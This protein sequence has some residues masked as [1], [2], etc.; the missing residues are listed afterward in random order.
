MLPSVREVAELAGVSVGTVSNYLNRPDRVAQATRDKVAR[1]I[2]TL[3]FVPNGVARQLRAGR[4]MSIGLVVLDVGNP[5]FTDVARGA[6]MQAAKAGFN[7]LLAN[8]GQ[9]P[10]RE[11]EYLDLFE[12]QRAAGL[13][14][15][16]FGDPSARLREIRER[17]MPV[18]LVDRGSPDGAY[19]SVS[20]DDF[21]GGRMAAQHLL[22]IGRRK[23]AFVGGPLTIRQVADRFRGAVDA[24]RSTDGARVDL[25]EGTALSVDEGDRLGREVIRELGTTKYD[26]VFAA[27]DLLAL[28]VLRA[29]YNAERPIAVP[30]EIAL[31]GYDDI[32]FAASAVVPISSVRQPRELIGATAVDLLLAERG[33]GE[34]PPSQHVVY[35]PELVARASTG[36]P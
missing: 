12:N 24:A 27:N 30:E 11:Q 32:S 8:S 9:D 5:F 19:P 34:R 6:E 20:V 21:A 26:G 10:V 13:L 1:A 36:R 35:V 28:G 7:I 33:E 16:P 31:I 25:Y 17:G 22:D 2:A 15:S 23:I 3:G 14:L 29:L 4:S 18:V